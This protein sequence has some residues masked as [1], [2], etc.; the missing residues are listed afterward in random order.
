MTIGDV[1]TMLPLNDPDLDPLREA[2]P[3]LFGTELSAPV[4]AEFMRFITDQND[5]S[6]NIHHGDEFDTESLLDPRLMTGDLP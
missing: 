6:A 5:P 2:C 3:H 1:L 4:V